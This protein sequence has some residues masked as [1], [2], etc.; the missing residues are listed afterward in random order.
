[1]LESAKTFIIVL[2][3]IYSVISSFLY[4]YE[5]NDKERYEAMKDEQLRLKEAEIKNR[6]MNVLE[7][8]VCMKEL[9]KLK[10]VQLSIS[11]ILA[12]Q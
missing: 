5:L 4:W 11:E 1:M 12:N 9:K 3:I 7:K 10:S 2:L 6:E 8:E